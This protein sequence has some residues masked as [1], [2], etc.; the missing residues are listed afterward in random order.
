MKDEQQ[1]LIDIAFQLV[2][3]YRDST[4]LQKQSAHE[5]AAWVASQLEACGF[6]TKPVGA[7]WGVL[8]RKAGL[9]FQPIVQANA[10]WKDA[11]GVTARR[12]QD[13]K[14]SDLTVAQR[15]NLEEDDTYG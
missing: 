7:S 8:Q 6:P 10:Q 1:R 14:E 9:V 5:V 15:R 4:V 2:L 13:A 3:T 11:V 12:E